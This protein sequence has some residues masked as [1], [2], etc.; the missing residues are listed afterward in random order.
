MDDPWGS[1]WTTTDIDSS[2]STTS[3]PSSDLA[4][5][6]RA[7]LSGANSPRIPA[8][9]E[10]APW[11]EGD[12]GFGDWAAASTSP[13]QSRW[14]GAW[15]VPSPNLSPVKRDD[16]SGRSSPIAWPDTIA[17]T[18]PANGS[19]VRQPSPDPWA[20]ELSSRRR[21][22]HH[23]STPRLVVDLDSPVD[24][25]RFEPLENGESKLDL[26]PDWDI[27]DIKGEEPEMSQT[28]TEE[29]V[30]EEKN[31]DQEASQTTEHV[32]QSRSSTPS[33][34][35]TDHD[36]EH[37]DSPI[38][39][40]DED[41]K[42]RQQEP[43]KPSGKVQ[44]LVVKFDGL[45]RA[46]SQE[47]LVVPTTS[48]ER[49]HS[50]GK[51]EASE[52][53][54]DFVNFEDAAEE[55]QTTE[56]SNVERPV[57]P[58]AQAPVRQ[59]YAQV[60]SPNNDAGSPGIQSPASLY[61]GITF[62]VKLDDVEKL[63][64]PKKLATA[65]PIID[66]SD[67]IP[68]QIIKDS[69]TEISERKTWYRISRFGSSRRHNAADDESYRRIIW[70]TS[71]VRD[72]VIRVVRRWMEEDSIAGR[73]A[74]GGGI[75]KTQKNM[76]G[77]DSSAEPIALD[78]VFGKK[79][80]HS[81]SASLKHV[82]VSALAPPEED[83]G[84]KTSSSLCGPPSQP[85]IITQPPVASFG[86]S[87]ASQTQT[88]TQATA[89]GI[90]A[91]PSPTTQVSEHTQPTIPSAPKT[92][93][94]PLATKTEA[95]SQEPVGD[96]DDDDEWGEMV[97]SPVE[98]KHP[99]PAFQSLGS[100]L[101]DSPTSKQ[102]ISAPSAFAEPKIEVG[103]VPVPSPKTS[104]QNADPWTTADFSL[105][106]APSIKP[107]PSNAAT[108]AVSNNYF[109]TAEISVPLSMAELRSS[110]EAA[111]PV[112]GSSAIPQVTQS[113]IEPI[114]TRNNN[115]DNEKEEETAMRIIAGLP[116]LSYMLR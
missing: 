42:G 56:T 116:D 63:F 100:A 18:K 3:Q 77:W 17:T 104:T 5:P 95:V 94:A 68:E 96:D 4:P 21:S 12:D 76:F 29:P 74:L 16:A 50:I 78:A 53:A 40:I 51:S 111:L 55:E 106:D 105:F 97:S 81:R 82:R 75:A 49:S 45:A 67:E 47:S 93:P 71:T 70:S 52:G 73:V 103:N 91:V 61:R 108:G 54:A 19:T 112:P 84:P 14:G 34:A 1:P 2:K 113:A 22:I 32:T 46:A 60:P 6:P 92:V 115:N 88:P 31:K 109:S 65:P 38:T 83:N 69:F 48:T 79:K 99:A 98:S 66:I 30:K 86:W 64:D 10:P 8:V 23:T 11:G 87:I 57:T 33:N 25:I 110:W 59:E 80:T 62:D 85:S 43:E 13:S 7:F 35:N 107:V 9:V 101:G 114:N 41:L 24:D 27:P 20:S 102:K 44:S 89:P 39:S 26:V 37:Q 90:P 72:D 36:D 28:S 58:P 15:A